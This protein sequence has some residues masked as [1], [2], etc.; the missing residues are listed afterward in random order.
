MLLSKVAVMVADAVATADMVTAAPAT[1]TT[2]V[3]AGMPAPVIL[4]PAP[5][6]TLAAA[7]VK[8]AVV[9]TVAPVAVN[10][11]TLDSD[12]AAV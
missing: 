4:C 2:V 7:S 10:K 1:D 5:T 12:G 6:R 8:V 9:M 11:P 3:P